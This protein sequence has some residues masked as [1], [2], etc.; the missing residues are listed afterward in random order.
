[1][2]NYIYQYYQAIKDGTVIAGHWIIEWYEYI[3]KGLEN[4]SF[5]FSPKKANA[6]ITFIENFCRH[7]QG[8]LGG[9]KVRLE[10]W[11][12]AMLS[13]LFGITDS[14]GNRQFRECFCVIG[15][16]NG[17]TLLASA[18]MAY[19][20]FCDGEYG[21]R[22]YFS[23]PKLEQANLCFDNFCQIIHTEPM[24]D[25]LATKRRT[26]IYIP[27]SNTSA[28]PLAFSAKKSDGLN[29]S[30]CCAD[31]T[32]SWIGDAGLK[33]YEVIK[34]SFGSRRQ[35]LLL[36]ITTAGYGEGVYDELMKRATRLLKGDS[37][38]TRF[39]PF[40]YQIDDVKKWNDINELQKSNPNLGVSVSV[41]YLLEEIA[42]AEGSLPKKAEYLTKY[43]NIKQNSS[44]AFLKAP[45]IEACCG[46]EL[47][48][49]DFRN[50]Y[51]VFGIDLSRSIDL[52][53]ATVVIE[54]EGELYVFAK[55]FLPS[56]KIEDAIARDGVPYNLY[57]Q[58]G[59]LMPS[60]ENYIDFHDCYNWLTELVTEYEILPLRVGYDRAMA[61]YLISDL[62][63]FG[64][65]CSDV[66]QGF[67]LSPII[68]E[69]EAMV[70]SHKIH[71]GNNSLLKMHFL[72][73]AVK[74]EAESERR[75][76]VKISPN[77][78]IDGMAAFLDAMCMRNAYSAEIGEQLKNK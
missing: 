69:T 19:L 59:F 2:N 75:K 60:G 73:S 6:C 26:D 56:E 42:V 78:H 32:S 3:V 51:A 66:Y 11:Q 13:V 36:S 28:K 22:I 39:A 46:E 57:I 50:S 65:I 9:Q 23:A 18:I 1:M 24:L 53:C 48:I 43:C 61:T 68:N 17:K 4:K 16:K 64:A 74:V 52:T 20:A 30:G 62:T 76:L 15:R 31:E 45:D 47:H 63:A 34:S 44:I 54:R 21:G 58:Q 25:K 8:T 5:F 38:E 40:I 77:E 49:E 29:I 55:F 37:R 71:L 10:L 27:S 41:D 70:E 12:K 72:N 7:S 33:F 67:N 14:E 35:P